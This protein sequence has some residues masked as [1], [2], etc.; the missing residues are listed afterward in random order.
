MLETTMEIQSPSCIRKITDPGDMVEIFEPDCSI[1][2]WERIPNKKIIEHF[3]N[4]PIPREIHVREILSKT[5][6]SLPN[7]L[8]DYSKLF[9]LPELISDLELLTEMYCD[10][11]DLEEFGFRFSN[12]KSQMCPK[13]HVDF[14]G[15]RMLCTYFGPGTEYLERNSE[16]L[17]ALAIQDDLEI[18]KSIQSVN[19][20][21]VILLK[22]ER[23]E[24]NQNRGAIHRSPNVPGGENRI[25]LSLDLI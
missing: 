17:E 23:W 19:P 12:V 15:I 16:N 1:L 13:F 3:S 7:L 21:D 18:I 2:I 11:L 5:E 20:L 4:H 6:I 24:G 22:G 9:L 25:I 14:V 8:S 10:L